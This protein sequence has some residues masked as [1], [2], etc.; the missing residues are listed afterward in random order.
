M[1]VT[2]DQIARGVYA[3][4]V[5]L[6]E[7]LPEKRPALKTG[8]PVFVGFGEIT[9]PGEGEKVD[10]GRIEVFRPAGLEHFAR[11]FKPGVSDGYLDYA[12]RG[13]F[14]NGGQ[15]CVVVSLSEAGG[16]YARKRALEKLFGNRGPLEDIEDVDLVCV[17]D[18]MGREILSLPNA[19]AVLQRYVLEYCRRTGDRFGVLDCAPDHGAVDQGVTHTSADYRRKRVRHALDWQS[20]IPDKGRPVEGA[21]YF[22]WIRVQPLPR[23]NNLAHVRIPPCGH[24]AGIYARSDAALG[25][26]KAP[27]NEIVEGAMD[28]ETHVSDKE[29]I[30]LNKS[31][32]NCLRSFPGRGIRIW[33]ARTLSSLPE[34]KYI[35]VRRLI[36][37]LV[38]WSRSNL[39]GFVFEP[40]APFVWDRVKDRVSAYCFELYQGG[41]LKG[42]RPSEAFFVKCDA[43][44]N[45]L[46]VRAAGQLICEVGLAP[47]IPAE[48]IVVHLIKSAAGTTAII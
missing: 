21:I 13:F 27:A 36:L 39:A 48:F 2:S 31:A 33:G 46:D 20:N 37:T 25:V 29:Q 28:L 12:I 24:V 40:N 8:V 35:N 30:E 45:P 44:N 4:G 10:A 7:V 15:D 3:P 17:P 38:R 16:G 11:C 1:R 42:Q 14:E 6:E 47:V 19:A 22:P 9:E 41:A 32:V 43:E 5:H 34:W 26:H 23:H 18:I